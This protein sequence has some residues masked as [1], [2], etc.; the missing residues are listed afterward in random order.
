MTGDVFQEFDVNADC[1]IEDI[2]PGKSQKVLINVGQPK[3]EGEDPMLH[4]PPEQNPKQFRM[5][6]ANDIINNVASADGIITKDHINKNLAKFDGKPGEGDVRPNADRD[7]DNDL[8][9]M[10]DPIAPVGLQNDI[11]MQERKKISIEE[12]CSRKT[13]VWRDKLKVDFTMDSITLLDT[14]AKFFR[15]VGSFERDP[16]NGRIMHKEEQFT[17]RLL[18]D[19]ALNWLV[20]QLAFEN[21]EPI[22]LTLLSSGEHKDVIDALSDER[23]I[24]DVKDLIRMAKSV[25][26]NDE[27]NQIYLT[28][29]FLQQFDF[30]GIDDRLYL[31]AKLKFCSGLL[32]FQ[33]RIYHNRF[34]DSLHYVSVRCMVGSMAWHRRKE[35]QKKPY[36]KFKRCPFFL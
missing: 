4:L 24:V 6:N 27:V 17:V 22:K 20:T 7:D 1:Y 8:E 3:G 28:P 26:P 36:P 25:K 19:R 5:N 23:N 15:E 31:R 35:S 18:V 9:V 30:K 32:G 29:H 14:M 12:M 11:Q 13:I 21:I 33:G 2:V 34:R 10:N 16:D